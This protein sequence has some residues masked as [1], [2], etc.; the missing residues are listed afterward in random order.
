M[1]NTSSDT[2]KAWIHSDIPQPGLALKKKEEE[3]EPFTEEL[4]SL[5]RSSKYFPQQTPDSPPRVFSHTIT[6]QR[7]KPLV[8]SG[9]DT[10]PSKL[11]RSLESD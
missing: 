1:F 4:I 9:V 7:T 8:P 10:I 3:E 5:V 11:L 2:T 6:N